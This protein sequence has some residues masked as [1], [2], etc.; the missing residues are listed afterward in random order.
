MGF[1]GHTLAGLPTLEP[2]QDMMCKEVPTLEPVQDMMCKEVPT[3][4]PVQDM[5]CVR[6]YLP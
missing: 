5:M 2:V 3:L 1:C 4:E 6:K